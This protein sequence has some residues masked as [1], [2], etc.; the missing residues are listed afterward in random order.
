MY[1]YTEVTDGSNDGSNDLRVSLCGIYR[2]NS[3]FLLFTKPLDFCNYLVD[4]N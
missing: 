1:V 3:C 4:L 2:L